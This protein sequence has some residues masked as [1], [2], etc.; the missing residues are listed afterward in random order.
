MNILFISATIAFIL[1]A[2]H[3][4]SVCVFQN[5]GELLHTIPAWRVE[6]MYTT[7]VKLLVSAFSTLILMRMLGLV[8]RLAWGGIGGRGVDRVCQDKQASP[9]LLYIY[10]RIRFYEGALPSNCV[11]CLCEG[12]NNNAV[13]ECGHAFHWTCI[14]PWLDAHSTC[15]LCM[16]RQARRGVDAMGR[17]IKDN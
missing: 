15:P 1:L 10:P 5:L 7:L 17:L 3:S 13:L 16:R 4:K 11:I 2:L 6:T 12:N 8:M 14:R 9:I